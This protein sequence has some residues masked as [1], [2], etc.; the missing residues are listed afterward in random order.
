MTFLIA[1]DALLPEVRAV[2]VWFGFEVH[3]V[4]AL[5]TAPAHYAIFAVGA[6]GFLRV[7][8]WIWPW[9]SAYA[10]YIAVSH[11]VW[12]LTSEQ[13]GGLHDGLV[14]LALFSVPALAL[15]FA[16]PKVAP[17]TKHEETP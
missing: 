1:R 5:A 11:L 14:Q 7:R 4:L 12:N 15:A 13:G 2:E 10:F 6:H 9:A 17:K 16:R 8:P 3:G